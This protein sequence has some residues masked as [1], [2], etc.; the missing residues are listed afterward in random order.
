MSLKCG[1][2]SGKWCRSM[3]IRICNAGK[4]KKYLKK[5]YPIFFISN[6]SMFFVL[7][8]QASSSDGSAFSRRDNGGIDSTKPPS[9]ICTWRSPTSVV[10]QLQY[11]SINQDL[12]FLFLKIL[13]PSQ[14][15]T[16][17]IWHFS[18]Y[19]KWRREVEKR[20]GEEEGEGEAGVR[21]NISNSTFTLQHFAQRTSS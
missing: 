9:L 11:F 18:D 3:R 13:S 10:P 20:V 6:L 21:K 7:C 19:L 2:W 16:S 1:S 14:W 4:F 8:H 5:R 17:F 15:K 12:L